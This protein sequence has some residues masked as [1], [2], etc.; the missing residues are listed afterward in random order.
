MD[1]IIQLKIT[2]QGTRPSIWRRVLVNRKTTFF[3]L[4]HIIQLAMGWEFEHMFEFRHGDDWIGEPDEEFAAMGFGGD[5]LQ[6]AST[7]PLDH[8]FSAVKEKVDY[9]Y[10]FGD[11]WHHWIV[12]EKFL[13]TDPRLNYPVCT[14]GK[15]NCPPED[16]G[17]VWGFYGLLEILEN[18][19]HPDREEM[20]EWLGEDYNPDHFDIGQVNQALVSLDDYI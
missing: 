9:L 15:L 5:R 16:C 8:V 13:T 12:A 4:H 7:L 19:Q 10:D 14:A 17:G 3:E 11:N 2:L 1:E 20:L 6:D 18:P